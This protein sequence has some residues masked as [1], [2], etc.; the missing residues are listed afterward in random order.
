MYL[1]HVQKTK[2]A[3]YQ[4]LMPS[5]PRNNVRNVYVCCCLFLLTVI[6]DLKTFYLF[7]YNLFQWIGFSYIFITILYRYF[8]YAIGGQN[9]L[10]ICILYKMTKGYYYL[11]Q[12]NCHWLRQSF[13]VLCH[14]NRTKLQHQFY[15]YCKTL[16]TL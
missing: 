16:K 10:I 9:M 13:V 4:F 3:I 5:I 15:E 6:H 8:F 1:Q 7:L 12:H 11:L 14:A 2:L